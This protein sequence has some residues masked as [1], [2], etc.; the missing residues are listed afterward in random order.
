MSEVRIIADP[1][2]LAGLQA[3]TGG[4][5]FNGKLENGDILVVYAHALVD[6]FKRRVDHG[7]L[8]CLQRLVGSPQWNSV[9]CS[10]VVTGW[11]PG[12]SY[13]SLSYLLDAN[14][15]FPY[16]QL[17]SSPERLLSG[18]ADAGPSGAEARAAVLRVRDV[19]GTHNGEYLYDAPYWGSALRLLGLMRNCR[20]AARDHAQSPKLTAWPA[21]LR[22]KLRHELAVLHDAGVYDNIDEVLSPYEAVLQRYSAALVTL[23]EVA[24]IA[25]TKQPAELTRAVNCA[26]QAIEEVKALQETLLLTI[27]TWLASQ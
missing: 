27:R 26:I 5:V 20:E 15:G 24:S 2:V 14:K 3:A 1:P 23:T 6:E 16:R 13:G 7:G 21:V 12:D 8:V 9:R 18:T 25:N 17:P 4:S 10:V 22:Q 19:F 11:L